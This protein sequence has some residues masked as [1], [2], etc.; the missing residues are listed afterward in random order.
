MNV[1]I[2]H[3]TGFDYKEELYAPLKEG[4]DGYTMFLPHEHSDIAVDTKQILQD[5]DLIVAE[6]SYPSTGQGI[7]LGWGN[8]AGVPIV[9]VH[10]TDAKPSSSLRIVSDAFI[11]YSSPKELALRLQQFLQSY[12]NPSF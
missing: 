3:S 6:V 11:E 2:S 10:H 12:D 1:Y 4:L 5:S 8:E 7:E 9:C